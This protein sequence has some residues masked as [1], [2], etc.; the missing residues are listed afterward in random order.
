VAKTYEEVL[1]QIEALKNEAAQLRKNETA[2]AIAEAKQIIEKYQLTAE[3]L[4][5][6]KKGRKAKTSAAKVVKYR[7]DTNPDDTYGGK[8]PLP[9]WLKQKIADG[10]KKEDF[11]AK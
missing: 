9:G 2:A 6:V 7:S 11:E 10:R 3:D 1:Q 5:L 8:G 4:G